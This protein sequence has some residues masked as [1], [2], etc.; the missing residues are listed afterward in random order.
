MAGEVLITLGVLILL[1]LV[2]QLWWTGVLAERTYAQT[3]AELSQEWQQAPAAAAAADPAPV[4]APFGR[5]FG[6]LY[7]PALG[8]SAWAVPVI[9]GTDV[10]LLQ[11]GVGHH[12]SSAMP[13]QLGN[14]A[15]AGHRT[16]YAAPFADID[17]LARGDQVI[18]ETANGWYV[19]VLDRSV[20]IEADEG[21]V[22]DPVPG[23]ARGTPPT[24]ALMTMY[25]CHPKFSAAQRFVWF[26]HL[27]DE[28]TKASG[29]PAA[30]LTHR[31]GA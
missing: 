4:K 16:T 6:L 20:V 15:I 2:W 11:R 17:S 25:A 13:G 23:K 1:F 21:W 12:V 18:V 8:N 29:T 26:G 24:Q 3:R 27:V 14:F 30:V 28:F 10:D 9:Q 7:I 5:P 22:L 19:Y 31:Q